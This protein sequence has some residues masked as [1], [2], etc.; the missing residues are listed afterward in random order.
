MM[1]AAFE[2]RLWLQKDAPESITPIFIN[3]SALSPAASLFHESHSVH[4]GLLVVQAVQ[5]FET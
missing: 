3:F 1:A 2:P 4:I 5:A